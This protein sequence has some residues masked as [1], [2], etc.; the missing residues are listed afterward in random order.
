MKYSIT[1]VSKIT[2]ISSS[3][4]RFYE[5]KGLLLPINRKPSGVRYFSEEDV[6][7]LIF[8]KELKNTGLS[9]KDI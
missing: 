2:K 1:D 4:I 9:I 7:R 3:A 5:E 8:I 6:E